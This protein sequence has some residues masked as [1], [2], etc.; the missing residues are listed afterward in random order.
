MCLYLVGHLVG[1]HGH[2]LHRHVCH[3]AAV[4]VGGCPRGAELDFLWPA[5]DGVKGQI[6]KRM[7][8]R[9][10]EGVADDADGLRREA[11][12]DR[13]VNQSPKQP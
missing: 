11:L 5:R 9:D 1:P 2:L 13:S 12:W 6:T 10:R 4:R 3:V 8:P 7:T